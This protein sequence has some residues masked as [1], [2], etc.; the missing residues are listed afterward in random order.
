MPISASSYTIQ[1][2]RGGLES[3]ASLFLCLMERGVNGGRG[4]QKQ[5]HAKWGTLGAR[6]KGV[7]YL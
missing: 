1:A 2:L 3:A 6:V 7:P 5:R 4:P